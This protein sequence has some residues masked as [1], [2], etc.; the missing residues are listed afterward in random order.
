M[1]A[2]W[3]D[4]PE[5]RNLG[6]NILRNRLERGMSQNRLAQECKLSQT[7]ISLFESGRR[8]PSLDQFVRIARAL[9]VPLQQLL[10]GADRSNNELKHLAVE[11]RKLGAADLWVADTVV[12]AAARPAEEVI[13]QAVSGARPDPRVVETI[14]ALLSWNM[15]NPP[16]LKAYGIAT[17]TT[18]RLAWLADVALAIDRQ[19]GFP[20]GCRRGS[21]ER[22]VAMVRV[23]P[24]GS[25]YDDLGM[26]SDGTP[27][28]PI[29]RRW[30]IRYG[31]TLDDFARRARSL[32]SLRESRIE[33]AEV[34]QAR[35]RVKSR[36]KEP[37]RGQ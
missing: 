35:V 14:P 32:V 31:A 2:Q 29:W 12:P 13:A 10:G 21:L 26:P 37:A 15:F 8:L 30:K 19:K 3:L 11:L 7:Q 34:G 27:T 22:F 25:P 18:Y 28:S 5:L 33:T 4:M 1:E 24:R 16:I 17:K 36:K 20:A 23:P 9:D 6:T